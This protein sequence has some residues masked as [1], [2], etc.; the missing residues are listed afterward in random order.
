MLASPVPC[1]PLV[2][3]WVP[4][5]CGGDELVVSRRGAVGA[6]HSSCWAGVSCGGWLTDSYLLL[7]LCRDERARGLQPS[8]AKSATLKSL[9]IFVAELDSA[10]RRWPS[11][12]LPSLLL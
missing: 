12:P 6:V 7:Y 2:M 5:G 11:P 10:G 9:G 8:V 4:R 1:S 3:V